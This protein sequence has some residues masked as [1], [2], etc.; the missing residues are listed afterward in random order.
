[1]SRTHIPKALRDRIAAQSKHR[2]G[3]CLS[4]ESI[5]G[6]LMES[7]HLLPEGLGG[8]TVEENLW[9]ACS[10]CNNHKGDRIAGF[11][12][13]TN[14]SV[15]LFNPRTQVWADHFRWTPEGDSVVGVSPCGRATEAT[16]NLNRPAIVVARRA[17]VSVGWHPP[18]D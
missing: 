4:A 8:L 15:P 17:W 2:C 3:H 18:V 16:L 5:V 6:M 7:D 14:E 1:M 11:D 13:V 10:S 9:L 12:A